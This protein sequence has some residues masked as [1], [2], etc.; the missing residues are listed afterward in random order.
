MLLKLIFAMMIGMAE[1]RPAR[2]AAPLANLGHA[3]A[4]AF[5]A[6]RGH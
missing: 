4:R 2:R 6:A 1:K 3:L 5:G